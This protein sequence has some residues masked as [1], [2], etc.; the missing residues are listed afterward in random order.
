MPIRW[1]TDPVELLKQHGY[2]SYRIRHEK[3]IGQQSYS[4]LKDLKPVSW[5]TLSTICELTGKQPGT[6]IE[7]VTEKKL[8]SEAKAKETVTEP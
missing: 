8:A 2:S 3:L 4:N 1:K 7:F 6:L 5:D